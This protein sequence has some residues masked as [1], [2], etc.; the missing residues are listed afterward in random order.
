[1]MSEY[2]E[3][4][5]LTIVR[6]AL[7]PN[8]LAD[9]QAETLAFYYRIDYNGLK[10]KR[11]PSSP[12][13]V[14]SLFWSETPDFL[15]LGYPALSKLMDITNEPHGQS[16]AIN[17]QDSFAAQP[18]HADM[19]KPRTVQTV[20]LTD[21]GAFDFVPEGVGREEELT[22]FCEIKVDAGDIVKQHRPSGRHRGRNQSDQPRINIG[23]Y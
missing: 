15:G 17:Y 16:F 11:G 3:A 5:D 6:N 23:R 19:Y 12:G 9:L 14:V 18:F 21:G 13:W 2:I 10:C 1:M 4:G 22:D 20:Q 7:D 8:L